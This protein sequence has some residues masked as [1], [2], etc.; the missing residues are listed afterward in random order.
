MARDRN[1][2][3]A[4]NKDENEQKDRIDKKTKVKYKLSSL[5]E[6]PKEA[7]MNLPLMTMI[8]MEEMSIENY[9]GVIEY[10]E[11]RIRIKTAQGIIKLEG[12][13]LNISQITSENVQ[14]E[15]KIQIIEFLN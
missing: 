2:N 3:N 12:R 14:V 6:L 9:K 13:K 7:V 4:M 15:G 10:S 11:E 1:K 5:F 8:G